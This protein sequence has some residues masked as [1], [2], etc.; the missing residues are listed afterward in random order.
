[1]YGTVTLLFARRR[2]VEAVAAAVAVA[3]LAGP[4]AAARVITKEGAV[5][6]GILLDKNSERV[7][8][9]TSGGGQITIPADKVHSIEGEKEDPPPEDLPRIV[10]ADIQPR[11]ADDAFKEAKDSLRAG[12]WERAGA[13]LAGLLALDPPR[14]DKQELAEAA[15]GLVTCYLQVED[16]VGVG[17]AL[18]KRTQ[19]ART[20]VERKRYI[21]A[22]EGLRAMRDMRLDGRKPQSCRELVDVSVKWKGEQL[23]DE[24]RQLAKNASLLSVRGRLERTAQQCK[25]KLQEA[26]QYI[27]GSSNR[28]RDAFLRM[29]PAKVM[30]A[31][32]QTINA[33]TRERNWLQ[34]N[35]W[36]SWADKDTVKAWADRIMAYL[37]AREQADDALRN[38]LNAPS[39]KSLY[40][41]DHAKKLLKQLDDLKYYPGGTLLILPRKTGQPS[42]RR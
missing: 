11:M 29:L 8:V 14:L 30:Q 5:F 34:G 37:S 39:L 41:A 2:A 22:A 13:L 28:H 19:F 4:L 16:P 35:R 25:D 21:T 31:A 6:E 24:A 26:D 23:I 27:P 40:D 3:L 42:R 17:K 9:R 12:K 10:P 1:M 32:D 15:E 38:L 36:R 20:D 33:C 7:V 18:L